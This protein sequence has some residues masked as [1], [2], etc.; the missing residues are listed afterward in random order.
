MK[1]EE[2]DAVIKTVKL[3]LGGGP[4]ADAPG[5]L[6][7]L[8]GEHG[9]SHFLETTHNVGL[10]YAHEKVTQAAKYFGDA[11]QPMLQCCLE[12]IQKKLAEVEEQKRLAEAEE[13]PKA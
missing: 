9:L 12:E 8:F 6:R 2:V 13:P 4:P 11:D 7:Y 10:R 3:E 5:L 1:I